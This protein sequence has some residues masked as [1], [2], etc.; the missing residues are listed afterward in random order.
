MLMTVLVIVLGAF[1]F[2]PAVA[3]TTANSSPGACH[4]LDASS[5]GLAGM[6]G[7]A[8]GPG[9]GVGGPNMLQ[10]VISSLG[11]GCTP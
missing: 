10:L 5:N 11:T 3:A 8:L 7:S 1:A 6:D 2:A 4:M 9:Q